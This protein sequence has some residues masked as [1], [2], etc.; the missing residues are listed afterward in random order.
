MRARAWLLASGAATAGLVA[1][2][3]IPILLEA[4]QG[5]SSANM[6]VTASVLAKCTISA[7][8]LAFGNYDPVQANFT[9]PLDAQTSVTVAC[10][11]GT[12]MNIA[13]DRGQAAN[14]QSRNMSAGSGRSLAY[15]VYKDPSRTQVWGDSGGGL[16]NGGLAPSREPRQFT[17]YGRVIGGQDIYEGSYQ[18]TVV[19]TVN[20]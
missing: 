19:V 4:R 11:K 10:T 12:A 13:M 9:A 8:P 6:Q 16:L 20:F 14:G 17:V 18:D 2:A 3:A 1:V 15:E 5:A 7:Q